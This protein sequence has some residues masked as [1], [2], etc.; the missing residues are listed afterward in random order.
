MPETV[1]ED[2]GSESTRG[3]PAIWP[4]PPGASSPQACP[5]GHSHY[6]Q[7]PHRAE[8][9]AR[10]PGQW[11]AGCDPGTPAPRASHRGLSN[12]ASPGSLGL[13][14]PQPQG[15]QGEEMLWSQAPCAGR[16]AA[17][18]SQEG[19]GPEP[20][21]KATLQDPLAGPAPRGYV[22]E[23]GRGCRRRPRHPHPCHCPEMFLRLDTKGWANWSLW[24]LLL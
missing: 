12:A 24:R 3:F 17:W 13:Q 6:R 21:A 9:E 5:R 8:D 11:R 22:C 7:H 4:R 23:V 2:P 14:E 20:A 10:V 15:L 1:A 16:G 19:P 18:S